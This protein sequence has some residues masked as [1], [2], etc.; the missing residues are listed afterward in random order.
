MTQQLITNFFNPQTSQIAL[1]SH[2]TVSSSF[3]DLENG[4]KNIAPLVGSTHSGFDP[5]DYINQGWW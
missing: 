2:L 4:T 1:D 5:W 3:I